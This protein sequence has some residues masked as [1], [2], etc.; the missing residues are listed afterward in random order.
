MVDILY[1]FIQN[2]LKSPLHYGICIFLY[3]KNISNLQK[4]V[5]C[6]YFVLLFK[7]LRK[8]Y[9]KKSFATFKQ[10][11]IS[12]RQLQVLQVKTG[13]CTPENEYVFINFQV[14]QENMIDLKL[15][16]IFIHV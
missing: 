3:E 2:K 7:C 15:W 8:C 16:F 12:W 14:T 10:L 6:Y 5:I 4:V 1:R 13:S 11:K 9:F